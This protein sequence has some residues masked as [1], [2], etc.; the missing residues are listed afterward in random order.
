M[1][2][3]AKTE[4]PHIVRVS[5]ASGATAVMVG[6]RL[7]VWWLIRQ[8][9]AGD[10]PEIIAEE[11]PHTNLAAIYDAI[12]YYHDHRDEIDPIIEYGDRVAADSDAAQERSHTA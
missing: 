4:L 8:L 12:S 11:F 5:G 7:S 1:V 2:T 10:T 3:Q 9:R 6:T